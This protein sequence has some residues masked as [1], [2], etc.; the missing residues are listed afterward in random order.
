MVPFDKL[1]VP[2]IPLAEPVEA[3]GAVPVRTPRQARGAVRLSR[4]QRDGFFAVP[5][6][7]LRVRSG[8]GAPPPRGLTKPR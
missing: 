3:N 6:D 2:L 4:R 8:G 5:F 7:K 1:K